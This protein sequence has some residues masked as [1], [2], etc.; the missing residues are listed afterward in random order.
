MSDQ[1][2]PLSPVRPVESAEMDPSF[3]VWPHDG[4]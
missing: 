4:G 3:V 1:D 2:L